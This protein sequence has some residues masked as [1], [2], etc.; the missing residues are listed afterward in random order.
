MIKIENPIDLDTKWNKLENYERIIK[1]YVQFIRYKMENNGKLWENNEKNW[2]NRMMK[3][4]KVMKFMKKYER[5]M[6]KKKKILI[7][8]HIIEL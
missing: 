3:N 7:E 5:I 2:Y 8:D 6:Q 4:N 1:K